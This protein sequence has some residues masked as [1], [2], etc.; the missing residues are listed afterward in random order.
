MIITCASCLTKFKLDDS[1]I[2]QKGVKVRCS[3]CHHVFYVVPPPETREEVMENFESFAKYHED[4]MVPGEEA[5]RKPSQEKEKREPLPPREEEETSPERPPERPPEKP[6][7]PE[8]PAPKKEE[9]AF[10]FE[11]K[12]PSGVEKAEEGFPEA[13][14]SAEGKPSRLKEKALKRE[15]RRISPFLAILVVLLLLIFGLFYL[16][17]EIGSGGRLSPIFEAPIQKVKEAWNKVWGTEKEGLDIGDLTGYEERVGEM[18]LFVIEGKVSNQSRFTKKQIKVKVTILDQDRVKM[19]EKEAVCGR[20]LSRQELK[21]QSPAFFKGEMIIKPQD[22]K[23][24]VVPS[25]KMAP[26]MVIFRDPLN[27]AKEFKV[28]IMEA[29][30]L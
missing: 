23:E 24:R 17:T 8:T 26:F 25:G 6:K 16:W 7:A 20:V 10:L 4:L 13:E 5:K 22:E 14:E 3:R 21:S 28:E 19:A 9:E 27:Q 1:R 2:S 15:R 12:T 18:P 11:E 29:P 30:N